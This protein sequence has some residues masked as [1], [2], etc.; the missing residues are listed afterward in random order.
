[1]HLY[2]SE[3]K[4]RIYRRL[5]PEILSKQF[6]LPSF[7]RKGKPIEYNYRVYLG[8]FKLQEV[9]D[10]LQ[11]LPKPVAPAFSDLELNTQNLS[12]SILFI[13]DRDGFLIDETLTCSTLPWALERVQKALTTRQILSLAA[14]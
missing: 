7:D 9:F 2:P 6:K 8:I 11:A 13:I 5:N 4:M 1:M 10:F 12:C 14:R 3:N